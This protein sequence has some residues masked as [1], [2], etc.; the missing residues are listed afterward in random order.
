MSRRRWKTDSA[1]NAQI[2]NREEFYKKLLYQDGVEIS[3]WGK[4]YKTDLFDGVE[5]PVGKLYEDIPTTYLLVEKVA[6]IAVIS[7]VDYY[8]FQRKTS[9]AQAA[10]SIGKMDAINHMYS[11]RCFI[12]ENYP[13]LKEA[14]DCRYFSTVCNILFQIYQSEFEYQRK[15][16]WNEVKKYRVSVLNNRYARK[17]S[18]LA[19]LVSYLGYNVM[20]RIY[21][22]NEKRIET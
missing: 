3:A 18:R 14:A 7:N 19:A 10:F 12:I 13:L 17:K 22:W 6:K 4:L 15:E 2:L 21:S 11:F 5:Y 1:K 9:I 20:R 16:L 8:Y